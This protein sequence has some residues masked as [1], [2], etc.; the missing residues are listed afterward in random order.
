MLMPPPRGQPPPA[1]APRPLI[2][3]LLAWSVICASVGTAPSNTAAAATAAASVKPWG[4]AETGAALYGLGISSSSGLPQLLAISTENGV[5]APLMDVPQL[6]P[7]SSLGISAFDAPSQTYF[8]VA[9]RET[10]LPHPAPEEVTDLVVLSLRTGT[11]RV[12]PL[13]GQHS[14]LSMHFDPLQR[15]LLA[16]TQPHPPRETWFSTIDADTG[17]VT[18]RAPLQSSSGGAMVAPV[19]SL[20]AFDVD[21]Q[22]YFALASD[23]A[24][25]P[26]RVYSMNAT[27]MVSGLGPMAPSRSGELPCELVSL[28]CEAST[29]LLLAVAACEEAGGGHGVAAVS[30]AGA[31][32]DGGGGG[33]GLLTELV[34]VNGTSG[35]VEPRGR[36]SHTRILN[37]SSGGGIP[38]AAGL[39]SSAFDGAASTYFS[40]F[41]D[42]MAT[43]G[44]HLV[45]RNAEI[46]S[47]VCGNVSDTARLTLRCPSGTFTGIRF[48]SYGTPE[49]ACDS[50]REGWCHASLSRQVM[51]EAC[52]GHQECTVHVSKFLFGNPC[53]NAS[54]SLYVQAVCGGRGGRHGARASTPIKMPHYSP[55]HAP[56]LDFFSSDAPYISSVAPG[57]GLLT[58]NTVV[59]VKG[60]HFF[61]M[62]SVDCIFNVSA[63]GFVVPGVVSGKAVVCV[64]PAAVSAA[65]A[66]TLRLAFRN[67]ESGVVTHRA[68]NSV[69]YY[70]YQPEMLQQASPAMGPHTGGTVINITSHDVLVSDY[71]DMACRFAGVSVPAHLVDNATVACITPSSHGLNATGIQATS[72]AYPVVRRPLTGYAFVD[73]VINETANAC[74][75]SYSRWLALHSAPSVCRSE[76]LDAPWL[77]AGVLQT[78]WAGQQANSPSRSP[79]IDAMRWQ[80]LH[81]LVQSVDVQQLSRQAPSAS[82]A[83][84]TMEGVDRVTTTSATLR[85]ISS[86][87]RVQSFHNETA[88]ESV[89]LFESPGI[90]VI[91][92]DDA[93]VVSVKGYNWTVVDNNGTQSFYGDTTLHIFPNRTELVCAGAGCQGI[94][95]SCAELAGDPSNSSNTLCGR[96]FRDV[97]AFQGV[98]GLLPSTAVSQACPVSCNNCPTA[99]VDEGPFPCQGV[100]CPAAMVPCSVLA[101]FG[102]C[103]SVFGDLPDI[104]GPGV[105]ATRP[106]NVACPISCASCTPAVLAASCS[107]S[108][109]FL[110]GNFSLRIPGSSVTTLSAMVDC[111]DLPQANPELLLGGLESSIVQGLAN[112]SRQSP[113]VVQAASKL[114]LVVNLFQFEHFVH[115]N[116]TLSVTFRYDDDAVPD[117][118]RELARELELFAKGQGGLAFTSIPTLTD[119]E[120]IVQS[121]VTAAAA[122][123]GSSDTLLSGAILD[124]TVQSAANVIT[125]SLAVG[126]ETQLGWNEVRAFNTSVNNM[127]VFVEF[128]NNGQQFKSNELRFTYY[129]PVSVSGLNPTN[130]P[131]AGHTSLTVYGE[132]FVPGPGLQCRFGDPN[133]SDMYPRFTAVPDIATIIRMG[134]STQMATTLYH[135]NTT[136]FELSPAIVK[137]KFHTPNM[138]KCSTP[139]WIPANVTLRVTNNGQQFGPVSRVYKYYSAP[140]I[141]NVTP[142]VGPSRG[143][144]HVTLIGES[145]LPDRN[146]GCM[147]GNTAVPGE[148]ISSTEMRC[149]TPAH[150]AGVTYV[151]MTVNGQQYTN[152]DNAFSFYELR[153]I[154]PPRG[155]LE[156]NTIVDVLGHGFVADA[157]MTCLF[158]GTTA[159]AA[160]FVN[161][162]KL[163]CVAPADIPGLVSFEI[164]GYGIGHTPPASAN[165]GL[166]YTLSGVLYQ[167]YEN[168]VVSSIDP[169]LGPSTGATIVTVV[170]ERFLNTTTIRCRF[171]T[172]TTTP[173]FSNSTLIHCPSP[174]FIPVIAN[175]SVSNN[176]QQYANGLPFEYYL[177][178]QVYFL[179]PHN[180]PSHQHTMPANQQTVILLHGANYRQPDNS[181]TGLLR[182]RFGSTIVSALFMSVRLLKCLLP[183]HAPATVALDVSM[184][185]QQYSSNQIPFYFYGPRRLD[186]MSPIHGNS[187]PAGTR[188]YVTGT[189]F[190]DGPDI[191]C[192]FGGLAAPGFFVSKTQ[193]YCPTP[194]YGSVYSR[195]GKSQDLVVVMATT[196]QQQYDCVRGCNALTTMKF[197]YTDTETTLS[198]ATHPDATATGLQTANAGATGR[199]RVQAVR[200]D[201]SS[202]T[203][204]QD[205]FMVDFVGTTTLTTLNGQRYGIPAQLLTLSVQPA[206]SRRISTGGY[207]VDSDD[208]TYNTFYNVTV[209]G[210]YQMAIKLAPQKGPLWAGY[211]DIVS[212]PFSVRVAPAA[213]FA[214]LSN[215]YGP[216]LVDTE[217]GFL[218]LFTIQARDRFNNTRASWQTHTDT[219]SIFAEGTD[220]FGPGT[221]SVGSH[222]TNF[223]GTYRGR[224]GPLTKAGHF[225]VTIAMGGV[226]IFASP[227]AAIIHPSYTSS[228][229][230]YANGPGTIGAQAGEIGLIYL[231][232]VD[233]YHNERWEGGDTIQSYMREINVIPPD[234]IPVVTDPNT[235]KYNLTYVA[236]Y[237]GTYRLYIKVLEQRQMLG[238][239]ANSLTDYWTVTVRPAKPYAGNSV[240][241]GLGTAPWDGL[242]RAQTGTTNQVMVTAYDIYGNKKVGGGDGNFSYSIVGGYPS[243]SQF[244]G[245]LVDNG[246]GTHG[247]T[248][249][250]PTSGPYNIT[251]SIFSTYLTGSPFLCALVPQSPAGLVSTPRSTPKAGD[252]TVSIN[253]SFFDPVDFGNYLAYIGDSSVSVNLKGFLDDGLDGGLELGW[254]D[255]TLIGTYDPASGLIVF[256]T[257]Q[258]PFKG[259]LA[260][261]IKAYGQDWSTTNFQF[262]VYREPSVSSLVPIAGPTTGGTVVIVDG[263]KFV[264]TGEVRCS[265]GAGLHAF[266]TV[267]SATRLRCV[268][269]LS[270][271]ATTRD[272]QV[273]VALNGQQFTTTSFGYKLYA[274]P[275]ILARSTPHSGPVTGNTTLALSGTNMVE[276]SIIL[277]S[278]TFPNRTVQGSLHVDGTVRCL[279][280]S[281][282]GQRHSTDGVGSAIVRVALNGQQYTQTNT[283]FAFFRVPEVSAISP[284]HG[285]FKGG[286]LVTLSGINFVETGEIA[287]RYGVGLYDTNGSVGDYDTSASIVTSA[288]GQADVACMTPTN[289]PQA[290]TVTL[291][292]GLNGQQFT[293]NGSMFNFVAQINS[294]SPVRGPASGGTL[295]QVVGE[296]FTAAGTNLVCKFGLHGLVQATFNNTK[297]VTCVSPVVAEK[298]SIV[299]LEISM[300]GGAYL[301]GNRQQF[302]FY[303]TPSVSAIGMQHPSL[304][305]LGNDLLM[306]YGTNFAYSPQLA[307]RF[308]YADIV[309]S[310]SIIA[311]SDASAPSPITCFTPDLSVDDRFPTDVQVEVTMNGQ[312]FTSDGVT[313]NFYDPRIP[314]TITEIRPGSGRQ[315]GSTKVNFVGTNFANLP[316]LECAFGGNRFPDRLRSTFVSSTS[317]FCYSPPNYAP[318]GVTYA[319][320]MVSVAVTNG[321]QINSLG[322]AFGPL[323]WS[324]QNIDFRFTMTSPIDSW[325][326]GPGLRQNQDDPALVAGYASSFT[327]QAVRQDGQDRITGG[328][329]FYAT[330]DQQCSS[331]PAEMCAKDNAGANVPYQFQAAVIDLD[332]DVQDQLLRDTRYNYLQHIETVTNVTNVTKGLVQALVAGGQSA[333]KYYVITNVTVS[334]KYELSLQTANQHI[335]DSPFQIAVAYDVI[336]QENCGVTGSGADSAIA[337]ELATLYVQAR[338]RWGNNRTNEVT[339]FTA[340]LAMCGKQSRVN[341]NATLASLVPASLNIAFLSAQHGMSAFTYQTTLAGMYQLRITSNSEYIAGTPR[342]LPVWPAVTHTPSCTFTHFPPEVIA[343]DG[344]TVGIATFDR[345]MNPRE[346]GGDSLKITLLGNQTL[347]AQLVDFG[348]STYNATFMIT[349]SGDYQVEATLLDVHIAQSPRYLLVRPAE[350][351]PGKCEPS[352]FGI[353]G[354]AVG[355]VNKFVIQARDRFGNR[356]DEPDGV[357]ISRF[358]VDQD[359]D[360]WRGDPP[361]INFTSV[362]L[363]GGRHL[364]SYNL[365]EAGNYIM[366]TKFGDQFIMKGSLPI[367]VEPA[368]VDPQACVSTGD[369]IAD[370][371]AGETTSFLLQLRD[372]Y[373]NNQIDDGMAGNITIELRRLV[374]LPLFWDERPD[375]K[376]ESISISDL[377]QGLYNISYLAFPAI[378]YDLYVRFN[379][380][381]VR[382]SPFRIIKK[383]APPPQIV[384]AKFD[385]S[386]IRITIVFDIATNQARMAADSVCDDVLSE[387]LVTTLGLGPV[388]MWKTFKEL[389]VSLGFKSIITT[390]AAARLDLWDLRMQMRSK[391]LLGYYENTHP[392]NNT[393]DIL[394]PDNPPSPVGIIEAPI[395]V[396]L[397]EPMILNADKSYGGG[398]RPLRFTWSEANHPYQQLPTQNGL[399]LQGYL[400]QINANNYNMF[401][402]AES[403]QMSIFL[404]KNDTVP[405]QIYNW[406]V[407]VQSFINK[408]GTVHWV[409]QKEPIPLP[410]VFVRGSIDV[411]AFRSD[412]IIIQGDAALPDPECVP[413]EWK[414]IDFMWKIND[415]SVYVKPSALA[416]RTLFLPAGTLEAYT[417]YTLNL[418]AWLSLAPEAINY[419]VV[420]VQ[421]RPDDLRP[422]I[423]GGDRI[424]GSDQNLTLDGSLSI[425]PDDIVGSNISYRWSCWMKYLPDTEKALGVPEGPCVNRSNAIIHFPSEF[426]DMAILRIP[427]DTLW[428]VPDPG[429][430]HVF[431]LNISKESNV[432]AW[433]DIRYAFTSVT[434]AVVFGEP[435]SISLDPLMQKKVN[436]SKRL[437]LTASATSVV[438]E[439]LQPLR[440]YVLQGTLNLDDRSVSTTGR[441]GN[442][443]VINPYRLI[444]GQTYVFRL[445]AEDANGKSYGQLTVPINAAPASGIFEVSPLNGTALETSFVLKNTG[446]ADDPEDMPLRYRFSFIKGSAVEKPL[447]DLTP[448]EALSVLLPEGPFSNKSLM[449]NATLNEGNVSSDGSSSWASTLPSSSAASSS[450]SWS[451]SG[452]GSGSW[453]GSSSWGGLIIG[454]AGARRHLLSN[455]SSSTSLLNSV[456]SWSG[457]DDGVPQ[458]RSW[459]G[460]S[461]G[462]PY[463]SSGSWIS[464][465]NHST[466]RT[467]NSTVLTG[468]ASATNGIGNGT[469]AGESNAT[470]T[471]V[472]TAAGPYYTPWELYELIIV[473]YVTDKYK[474]ETR[475][476]YSVI[477]YPPPVDD[478]SG[479]DGAAALASSMLDSVVDGASNVGDMQAAGQATGSI[480]D[481]LNSAKNT[482]LEATDEEKK[483]GEQGVRRYRRRL[484]EYRES[485]AGQNRSAL[486][487]RMMSVAASVA[488]GS[489]DTD[490]GRTS[491]FQLTG[492]LTANAG[493]MNPSG[494]DKG[495]SLM[496]SSLAGGNALDPSSGGDATGALSN[497]LLAADLESALPPTDEAEDDPNATAFNGT[498]RRE[499]LGLDNSSSAAATASFAFVSAGQSFANISLNHTNHTNH[500][501]FMGNMSCKDVPGLVCDGC[502]LPCGV[503]LPSGEFQ[504]RGEC[505]LSSCLCDPYS[506]VAARC[507]QSFFPEDPKGCYTSL[508]G[509]VNGTCY[510]V[511][512]SPGQCGTDDTSCVPGRC[513]PTPDGAMECFDGLA[514]GLEPLEG[515]CPFHEQH[516]AAPSCESTYEAL[517]ASVMQAAKKAKCMSS[518]IQGSVDG[519]SGSLLKDRVLGEDDVDVQTGNIK[520]KSARKTPG[521]LANSSLKTPGTDTAMSIPGEAVSGEAGAIDLSAKSW[522]VNPFGFSETSAT[523]ASDVVS[524]SLSTDNSTVGEFT[525]YVLDMP[526]PPINMTANGSCPNECSSPR[527]SRRPPQGKCIDD[528]CVCYLGYTGADCSVKVECKYWD[529]SID[530]WSTAGCKVAMQLP[531]RTVCHCTHLSDFGGSAESAMPSM[532]TVDPLDFDGLGSFAED[533]R[534]IISL[535]LVL[536]LYFTF[537]YLMYSGHKKDNADR[538]KA[539]VERV[540]DSMTPKQAEEPE[541]PAAEG[542]GAA[543]QKIDG[544]PDDML[545]LQDKAKLGLV[546]TVMGRVRAFRDWWK[547]VTGRAMDTLADAHPWVSCVYVRPEDPFTRPQRMIVLLSVIMGNIVICALFFEVPP[548]GPKDE[549][550]PNCPTEPDPDEPPPPCMIPGMDDGDEETDDC[551][552]DVPT[553]ITSV[554]IGFIML[555][556]DRCFIGMFAKVRPANLSR[557]AIGASGKPWSLPAVT[558]TEDELVRK[559]QARFRGN[560]Q[561]KKL[562]MMNAVMESY[563]V[564]EDMTKYKDRLRDTSV[565]RATGGRTTKSGKSFAMAKLQHMRRIGRLQ[566]L[567]QES[568]TP[569]PTQTQPPVSPVRRVAP[570]SIFQGP[571]ARLPTK[572]EETRAPERID[573]QY[574]RRRQFPAAPQASA[575]VGGLDTRASQALAL[576]PAPPR[577]PVT[578][579]S[580]TR[581]ARSRPL[582]L[583]PP[584]PGGGA[585]AGGPNAMVQSDRYG[586]LQLTPSRAAARAAALRTPPRTPHLTTPRSSRGTGTAARPLPTVPGHAVLPRAP[587]PAAPGT[588]VRSRLFALPGS[589][590]PLP[591]AATATSPSRGPSRLGSG[592]SRGSGRV[593]LSSPEMPA[594]KMLRLVIWVQ[595]SFR[596][597]MA[598]ADV[599][600]MIAVKMAKVE[601][602]DAAPDYVKP[603]SG[604]K[605]AKAKAKAKQRAKLAAAA[606]LEAK[607]AA[608]EKK[609]FERRL[610]KKI[611][612]KFEA[613][614]ADGSGTLDEDELKG[615][616]AEIGLKLSRGQLRKAMARMDGDESGEVDFAEFAQWYREFQDPAKQTGFFS[617]FFEKDPVADAAKE[618]EEK[619]ARATQQVRC[620][621]VHHRSSRA[622]ARARHAIAMPW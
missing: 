227:F 2:L 117:V 75:W 424:I 135:M 443:L 215:A 120:S 218:P 250:L 439:T 520:M 474:A 401:R 591:G 442:N 98:P 223:D 180:G 529:H 608:K 298:G 307:V 203:Y 205:T 86:A 351:V 165:Y 276:T 287:C 309:V 157:N 444:P 100:G 272:V 352:G 3:H 246:D 577:V 317:M 187:A 537:G 63:N 472:G 410:I 327:I 77:A 614:D 470:N 200:P 268:S 556:C 579:A 587:P 343:G 534:N 538:H 533:P 501:S 502:K 340:E 69:P 127:S 558:P 392:V 367:F 471:T 513:V 111:E 375:L 244:S 575:T 495:V 284:D 186:S 163:Q 41:D 130:G 95:V 589:T 192:T 31:G 137:A 429:H 489:P 449:Y 506:C 155:P 402:K 151:N 212:S 331:L 25:A 479:G 13:L 93:S 21:R 385:D 125:R 9:R 87:A 348:D 338:D 505:F 270:T 106:I 509:C 371:I 118:R 175:F 583:P 419:A 255:E 229:T 382:D 99:C 285:S 240:A 432:S 546:A 391:A 62:D 37:S 555:P 249:N 129:E 258:F 220:V 406:S 74:R 146:L 477:V 407:T 377:R 12:V 164:T 379:G 381:D 183:L 580:S 461:D 582:P 72:T 139:P 364:M 613:L 154:Y 170:G 60:L 297:L 89:V 232:T 15:R 101:Q 123:H 356:R 450:A 519:V 526:V 528:V 104:S 622:V 73:L 411:V 492:S 238:V 535:A 61:R 573:G 496:S 235:G 279:S 517:N 466:N 156:G 290:D 256:Q 168:L 274:A 584:S 231:T 119:I 198:R 323:R 465:S 551:M 173:V 500:T 110:I 206:A 302:E 28:E 152:D 433:H 510:N 91:V 96:H 282:L 56:F 150:V 84:L 169:V 395:L 339:P 36:N 311:S 459:S 483:G 485:P 494:T 80:A 532:N 620:A 214:A 598:R 540:L 14:V 300:D 109:P 267:L 593:Y 464:L 281:S 305:I 590:P 596:G 619:V 46:E 324:T 414:K 194:V 266:A 201:G 409:A 512:C 23:D 563:T 54:R 417:V 454:G 48:A 292:V 213:T 193:I 416:S 434:I 521:D 57:S 565:H 94:S 383:L 531:D 58:G 373:Q 427:R 226:H 5:A 102:L 314:P 254:T 469:N 47:T 252:T 116:S 467:A 148:Y 174:I 44:S 346:F 527:K 436:P 65:A 336:S 490:V 88:N 544:V 460:S 308:G 185:G 257:P 161:H 45:A 30:A 601:P 412:E 35:A 195:L 605:A 27:R 271:N 610:N 609:V 408:I 49:G 515:G 566:E 423:L 403:G 362:Y 553:L 179:A 42:T 462:V 43:E 66:A 322:Q 621:Q 523:L 222:T 108:G 83:F 484:A 413:P 342:A 190:V 421:V 597:M 398:P 132:N 615:L 559:V 394:E 263:I 160:S 315:E 514:I 388:C 149:I 578:R 499:V 326:S 312:Q 386:L 365:S 126:M 595:A 487:E 539:Y 234:V 588:V 209:S 476:E 121:I 299:F 618:Y 76:S 498:S 230:S 332:R 445:Q 396:G 482:S 574:T 508:D 107:D 552:L 363:G 511:T 22:T 522:N 189:N 242:Y 586:E 265:F 145:F 353:I 376:P 560:L 141:F 90:G 318:D 20:S 473:S 504:S 16:V 475:R 178:P 478:A 344:G 447:A 53:A 18:Q 374:P 188:V 262:Q 19:P 105:S 128:S 387:Y 310:A 372:K 334:G 617:S 82:T 260:M 397:C 455:V 453:S 347:D 228:Y 418:T 468:N 64:A 488:D 603:E 585:A 40:V 241:A 438:P 273:R 452:S 4:P 525:P 131:D 358:T 422:A 245:T 567:G 359:K 81:T 486:R 147:F 536:G 333:G 78:E 384:E 122:S 370:T 530:A 493:E 52:V 153:E 210:A 570:P 176:D 217:A 606:E 211:P 38:A 335:R 112:P 463:D 306:L 480:V 369:G 599:R 616:L 366:A 518:L 24:F 548:C 237:A 17:A 503:T 294:I 296:G 568:S 207:I 564:D 140:R 59:T 400:Q 51:K 79:P 34:R 547:R 355:L 399:M 380:Q 451:S 581:P 278:F 124:A 561:R 67:S 604:M 491:T 440:W 239:A 607:E 114:P 404:D 136:N 389:S 448:N 304:P 576:Q 457:S 303:P 1:T 291:E 191:G 378:T 437:V 221:T 199:F 325:A 11:R 277:C 405:G 264:E 142:H 456:G 543:A 253:A 289:F 103:T 321:R 320:G 612:K 8:S 360:P 295:I 319:T 269:P 181:S 313:L 68:S 32:D 97:S 197:M 541:V 554:I 233:I 236:T 29:G 562:R 390:T 167:Y 549:G 7:E 368:P 341:C 158:N 134:F 329:T 133:D 420:T 162:Q 283:T 224:F 225:S 166:M 172:A 248:Y 425:D 26:Q 177:P 33:G 524:L 113:A 545:R 592:S 293:T 458:V 435:P 275:V 55:L 602:D 138:V 611:R 70:Y 393:A 143:G 280:P 115:S 216:G 184:N 92:R 441:E 10:G 354:A 542:D 349:V 571:A 345:F 357:F 507:Q 196:N 243:S 430:P 516:F 557:S 594:E 328:D 286:T 330:F 71:Y 446:W 572:L 39:A 202:K 247:M 171:G 204:G 85:G 6:G 208:G 497:L 431:S 361:P 350:I 481:M 415:E 569:P 426:T 428:G 600:R 288:A 251:I 301:T 261:E 259:T 550:Y 316:T 159:V 219:Y 144:T 182:C 337:G 50:Y